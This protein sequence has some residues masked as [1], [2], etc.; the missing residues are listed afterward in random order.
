MTYS[1]QLAPQWCPAFFESDDLLLEPDVLRFFYAEQGVLNGF[2]IANFLVESRY[3]ILDFQTMIR[4]QS[5]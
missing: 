1:L 3:A 2:G 5:S 4:W